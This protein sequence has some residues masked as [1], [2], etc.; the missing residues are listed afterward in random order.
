MALMCS[1]STWEGERGRVTMNFW[2][3]QE[4][5][6]GGVR[7]DGVGWEHSCVYISLLLHPLREKSDWIGDT[8]SQ[9]FIQFVLE[10]LLRSF[11]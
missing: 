6:K 7:W 11:F 4:T 9:R 1:L 3:V 5:Q 2:P 10:I 8:I